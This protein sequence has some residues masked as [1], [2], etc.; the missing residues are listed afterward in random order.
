MHNPTR[1]NRNI[2]TPKQ[3]HA[4]QNEMTIPESWYDRRLFYE[5]LGKTTLVQVDGFEILVEQTRQQ[6]IHACTVEDVIYLLKLIPPEDLGDLKLIVLRQ[7]KRKEEIMNPVWGRLIYKFNFQETTQTAILLE[8]IDFTKKLHFNKKMSLAGR[9]E[10]S[11]L[12]ADGHQF[13]EGKK[14]FTASYEPEFVRATQLYRTLLHEIGHYVDY[15]RYVLKYPEEEREIHEEI[16]F[17]IPT[18]EKEKFAHSYAEKIGEMLRSAGKIPFAGI[19][20]QTF[21]EAYTLEKTDF[22]ANKEF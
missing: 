20:N 8:A 18:A 4:P 2:G 5:K 6:S 19:L 15:Q 17:R 13:L 10:F 11:R 16:Y 1:R 21:L 9:E 7:P 3:G 22:T 12:Q 14:Y